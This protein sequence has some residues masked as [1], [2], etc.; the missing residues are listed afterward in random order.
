VIPSKFDGTTLWLAFHR[1]FEA[2]ADN[3]GWTS[4]E[5]AAHL[6]HALQGRAV[7]ILDID[8]ISRQPSRS[9]RA[10]P[11]SDSP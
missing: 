1:Q 8:W 4:G 7:D 3:S 2:A 9:W 6:L 10:G 11:L 5:K